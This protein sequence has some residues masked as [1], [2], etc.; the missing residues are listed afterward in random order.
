[1]Q[2]SLSRVSN[3]SDWLAYVERLGQSFTA[4]GI[5]E[6]VRLASFLT[7]I[8]Q[9]TY[10][11]LRDIISPV[12]PAEQLLDTLIKTLTMNL[13]YYLN[14]KP[15]IISERFKFHR[16]DQRED[17]SI[18]QYLTALRRLAETCDFRVNREES[19]RDRLV[20]GIRSEATQK[21]Y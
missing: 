11:L 18:V 12:K 6:D 13:N 10:R 21:T 8:G 14:P 4:Y 3:A 2:W 5:K 19:L 7:V 15:I 1:M 16:R 17:E 9:K 20:C